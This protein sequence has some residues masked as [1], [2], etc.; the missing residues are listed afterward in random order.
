MVLLEQ[1]QGEKPGCLEEET[2][3]EIVS[4]IVAP[5]KKYRVKLKNIR[6]E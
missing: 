2:I 4:R 6:K 1:S 5:L 3:N